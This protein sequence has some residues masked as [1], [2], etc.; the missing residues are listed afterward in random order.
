MHANKIVVPVKGGKNI[1]PKMAKLTLKK[2]P[3]AA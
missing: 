1:M 2:K 3:K